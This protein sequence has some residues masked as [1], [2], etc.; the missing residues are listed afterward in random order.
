MIVADQPIAGA[1]IARAPRLKMIQHQGVGYERIDI[2]ACRRRGI[3]VGLT[4]EGT[5]NRRS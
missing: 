4:P 3:L 1:D 5:S 2:E